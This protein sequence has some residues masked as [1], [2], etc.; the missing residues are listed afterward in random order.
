MVELWNNKNFYQ[1]NICN[2]IDQW[3]CKLWKCESDHNLIPF[4]LSL[5]IWES[6]GRKA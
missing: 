2:C 3:M 5:H 4:K 6:V 1:S